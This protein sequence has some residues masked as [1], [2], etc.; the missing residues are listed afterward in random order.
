VR[1][2]R[3]LVLLLCGV[4]MWPAAGRAQSQATAG[5]IAGQVVDNSGAVLPGATVTITSADTGYTRTVATGDDGLYTLT[6][7]PPGTYEIKAELAGF[8]TATLAKTVVT[9]GS[10]LSVNITLPVAGVA[11][12]VTVTSRAAAVETNSSRQTNTLNTKAIENLPINGRRFQDFV[13]LTPTAQV[14]NSRG[15]I[16]LAG[17]RGINSNISIDGADYNQPFFGGIRGGERSNFAFTIPQ[18]AIGEFQVVS[19]GFSA[20]FGRSSGGLVNAV[21]KAGTNTLHG[22]AFYLNRPKDLAAKNAFDQDAATSSRRSTRHAWC[23]SISSS[24]RAR[25]RTRPRPSTST[26]RSKSRSRTPTTRG[27]GWAAWTRNSATRTASTSATTAAATA[28]TTARASAD[29]SSPPRTRRSRTTAPRRT[30]PTPSSV[31]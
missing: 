4:A 27:R 1:T 7:I 17:Q 20:E 21:T 29:A 6:A 15:Q 3:I 16:S 22:S 9:V 23:C 30:T 26:S 31:S 28:P 11:E 14:D 5:Q 2:I 24:A 10:N 13:S 12:N 25:A 18:E 8:Q 19:S